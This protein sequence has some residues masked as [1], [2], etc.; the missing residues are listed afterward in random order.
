MREL[1]KNLR[2]LEAEEETGK[3]K[4]V[5]FTF[6]RLNPPTVGHELLINRVVAL[7]D[8]L[9]ADHFIFI[10]RTH[11]PPKDPLPYKTKARIFKMAFPQARLWEEAE[12]AVLTPH[13][14][15]GMLIQRY[16]N[17]VMVV[18]AD[19]VDEFSKIEPH[20]LKD[21][22]KSFKVVSAGERDP[23]AEGVTGMSASKARAMAANGDLK[24]FEA[25]IPDTVTPAMKKWIYGILR[26]E[27]QSG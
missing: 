3:K 14:V 2:L 6:G 11:R 5:V 7:A 24:G 27:M 19:R 12:P 10:S 22:A 4:T 18:G 25:A 17:L 16:E 8:R 26:K 21:G 23:D 1:L 15:V 9:G 20:A 13:K